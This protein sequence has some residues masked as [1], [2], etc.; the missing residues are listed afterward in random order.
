LSL[1]LQAADDDDGS[2]RV[3]AGA[4]LAA[5][6]EAVGRL[7]LEGLRSVVSAIVAGLAGSDVPEDMP[8]SQAGLD[9]LTFMEL[10]N[11]LARSA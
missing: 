8:L 3:A 9:S 10:R 2:G 4:G 5:A 7:Q 1:A 6:D 11:E